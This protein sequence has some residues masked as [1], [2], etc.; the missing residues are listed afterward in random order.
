MTNR[1]RT[2][3]KEKKVIEFFLLLGDTLHFLRLKQGL[4]IRLVAAATHMS[5]KVIS[6]LEKGIHWE[7]RTTTL[8]KLCDFYELTV[9]EFFSFADEVRKATAGGEQVNKD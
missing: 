5:H 2:P 6:R 9:R 7:V 1:K 4:S 8:G 3:E